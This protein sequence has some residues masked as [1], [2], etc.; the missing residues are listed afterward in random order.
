M[1]VVIRVD[2]STTV[3]SGHLMRCL[4]FAEKLKSKGANI[5]FVSRDLPG[6]LSHLVLENKYILHL[7]ARKQLDESLIGY[8][9]WLTVSQ[10]CDA[11]E[12]ISI[13]KS[14]CNTDD[15]HVDQLI[16][17]SYAI[18][19]TWESM[20]R[21]YVKKIFVLDDL[22]N[23]KHDCDYLLDQDLYDDMENRYDGLVPDSCCKMLGPRY[24]LLR[25]EFYR[26]RET[27]VSRDGVLKNILIFYGGID[28]TNET[29]K[30][31]MAIMNIRDELPDVTVDVIVGRK[32]PHKEKIKSLCLINDN[33]DWI[34]FHEQVDN[35]ADYMCKADLSLGAG[36][37]TMWERCFLEL[38]TIVTAVADNQIEVC[39]VADKY[40]IIKYLGKFDNVKEIDIINLL[41]QCRDI[42]KEM[43]KS[44]K[45]NFIDKYNF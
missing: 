37:T 42:L 40:K 32:N 2:S 10:E 41:Y 5:H 23:R 33:R 7:L 22:A 28:A 25:E 24:M 29:T 6:N 16:V 17:D 20:L 27:M 26:V 44:I 4:T 45:R 36:G 38:P 43:Q 11:L 39:K 9:K 14:I 13:I 35:I 21:P 1:L 18:D 12:T 8:S 15:S 31:L 3:G 19:R 34:A 30:A